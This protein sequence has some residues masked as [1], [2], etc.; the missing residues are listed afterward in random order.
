MKSKW[1]ERYSE[2]GFAYGE[3]PNDFLV[4]QLSKIKP[5]GRVLS[6][7]EGEGRN[8]IFLASKGLKVTG[9]DASEIGMKKAKEWAKRSGVELETIVSDLA[10]FDFGVEKWDA[11]VSIF[12]HLPTELRKKIYPKIEVSL[13]PGGIL[14]LEAYRPEQLNHKT[15]G[16]PDV[17][18][19]MNIK[20]LHHEF[21]N[22]SPEVER[23]I[24]REIHEGK[25]HNG[26]SAVVQFVGKMI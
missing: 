7:A 19:L 14:I 21:P 9:V 4:S 11:V 22:L 2:E 26:M 23:E 12:A 10:D 3:R 18:L 8:G 16:P 15:G 25:Y 24:E 5:G 20:I 6:I 1:D 17:D 13:K